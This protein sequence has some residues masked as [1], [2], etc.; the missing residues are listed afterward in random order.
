M[1]LESSLLFNF[2]FT[3]TRMIVFFIETSRRKNCLEKSKENLRFFFFLTE[4]KEMSFG[5]VHTTNVPVS[6]WEMQS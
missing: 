5:C 2:N 4:K 3:T 6:N 1:K